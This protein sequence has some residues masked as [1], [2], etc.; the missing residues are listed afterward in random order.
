MAR[1][2]SDL[3]ITEPAKRSYSLKARIL[4]EF[5]PTNMRLNLNVY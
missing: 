1:Q 5:E 4:G 3:V 2:V